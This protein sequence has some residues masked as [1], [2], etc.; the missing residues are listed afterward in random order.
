MNKIL[1]TYIFE[2]NGCPEGPVHAPPSGHLKAWAPTG[3]WYHPLLAACG[4]GSRFAAIPIPR[5]GTTAHATPLSF[6]VAGQTFAT[7]AASVQ[8]GDAAAIGGRAGCNHFWSAISPAPPSIHWRR[9]TSRNNSCVPLRSRRLPRSTSGGS[10][11]AKEGTSPTGCTP[12][13]SGYS[14][15]SSAKYR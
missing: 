13:A 7:W 3:A 6:E 11:E 4:S 15:V 14:L 2:C 5:G 9:P 10:N 1:R 8:A 12:A